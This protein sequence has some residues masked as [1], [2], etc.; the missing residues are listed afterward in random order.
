[1]PRLI[2]LRVG[3]KDRVPLSDFIDS[4]RNFLGMLRDYDAT[5]SEDVHG[6]VVWEVVQLSQNS[7]PLIGVSPRPK[8]GKLDHSEAVGKR[9]IANT[10]EIT[11]TGKRDLLMSDAV[12]HRLER[13]AAKT[14][15]LG[16]Y[17]IFSNG[18]GPKYET[19]ISERT[20]RNV[21]E[22]TSPKYSS[23]G[24]ITGNLDAITVHNS[25][26]FRV[27]DDKT[28]KPV[29]CRFG[30]EQEAEVKNLLRHRVTVFGEILSNSAGQPLSLKLSRLVDSEIKV[31]PTIAQMRGLV[32]DFTGGK[33]L[34]D[35]LEEL[36]DE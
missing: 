15:A 27:W 2:F 24:T 35:Y 3:T 6:S 19:E 33:P 25:N 26:E 14:T 8:L 18:T 11:S 10:T 36:S 29:R 23:F 32:K 5:L 17:S 28:N 16:D 20:L 34:K 9:I 13:L 12:L 22:F 30:V 21:Q 4:L 31:P 1:M 7:P